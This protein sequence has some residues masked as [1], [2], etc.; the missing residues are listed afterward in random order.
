MELWEPETSLHPPLFTFPPPSTMATL[1]S[2]LDSSY[3]PESPLSAHALSGL[4]DPMARP[5]LN[6]ATARLGLVLLGAL[7]LTIAA[8]LSLARLVMG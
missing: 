2:K 8:L 6:P 1:F 4:A 5:G 7:V 3:R